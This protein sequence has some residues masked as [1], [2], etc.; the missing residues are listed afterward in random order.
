MKEWTNHPLFTKMGRQSDVIMIVMLV[1]ILLM[2]I[3]PLPAVLLD[4]FLSLNIALSVLIFLLAFFS[5]HVLD[6]SVFPSILL[7]TTIF[8]LALNISSTRLILSTGDPGTV[9]TGFANFVT[10]GDLVVGTL[11]FLIM[12]IVQFVVIN[13][14]ASRVSEVGAR[15]TLDAMPGKQ[16]N[17]DMELNAG[18]IDKEEA[19]RRRERLQAER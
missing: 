8:R 2:I 18:M 11:I 10:Q 3:V 4:V 15:F 5:K 13:A 17:I 16:M 9:V 12:I 1:L 14:G 7:V 6:F 19:K